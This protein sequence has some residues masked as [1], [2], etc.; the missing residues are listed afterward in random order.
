[1]NVHEL[2][3]DRE[4]KNL[5]I[6]GTHC[7]KTLCLQTWTRIQKIIQPIFP[8]IRIQKSVAFFAIPKHGA[9]WRDDESSSIS[10]HNGIGQCSIQSSHRILTLFQQFPACSRCPS[11]YTLLATNYDQPHK[12]KPCKTT[13]SDLLSTQIE[14]PKSFTTIIIYSVMCRHKKNHSIIYGQ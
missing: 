2:T 8:F 10:Q 12:K 13:F 7:Y 4:R 1:M 6:Y 11:T 14:K 5:T 9:C 3:P